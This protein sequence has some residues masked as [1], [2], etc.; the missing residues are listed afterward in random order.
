MSEKQPARAS[1]PGD[2][3]PHPTLDVP[4]GPPPASP[5]GTRGVIL[6][7]ALAALLVAGFGIVTRVRS[8][9]A[10]KDDTEKTAAPTVAV[11]SPEHG[12]PLREI[13]LPGTTQAFTDAPIYA[14]TSGY[15][16]KWHVDIGAK[17]RKGQLLDETDSPE[18]DQQLQAAK[19]DHATALANEQL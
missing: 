17:V 1:A 18:I 13:L 8:R 3:G 6:A 11:F 2:S 15:L 4:A 14:R 9:S 19:A 7:I 16:R 10:L 12:A 5:R